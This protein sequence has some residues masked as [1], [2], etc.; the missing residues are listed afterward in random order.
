MT[1]DDYFYFAHDRL[2]GV[3]WMTDHPEYDPISTAHIVELIHL[4]SRF[5]A[6]IRE[7]NK[8]VP[9]WA[10]WNPDPDYKYINF[11][12]TSYRQ[13][14]NL[15]ENSEQDD[16]SYSDVRK[17]QEVLNW[18]GIYDNTHLP[19]CFR[20][21]SELVNWIQDFTEPKP[22][23]ITFGSSRISCG[24]MAMMHPDVEELKSLQE[25]AEHEILLHRSK[26]Q[27]ILLEEPL[28]QIQMYPPLNDLIFEA[29]SEAGTRADFNDFLDEFD[30]EMSDT[31]LGRY[32]S[33]GRAS[34]KQ[35][36][37]YYLE[38]LSITFTHQRPMNQDDV[39]SL[40]LIRDQHLMP[41]NRLELW[42]TL[43][44]P[45]DINLV[46]N[47]EFGL[48][49]RLG[50][51]QWRPLSRDYEVED[52]FDLAGVTIL[53]V[54]PERESEV[55]KKFDNG[56]LEG[57][58]LN[59][60]QLNRLVLEYRGY[61]NQESNTYSR[62]NP[63][64]RST[65]SFSSLNAI[66]TMVVR[67]MFFELSTSIKVLQTA[68][69]DLPYLIDE[70]LSTLDLFIKGKTNLKYG[71]LSRVLGDSFQQDEFG[72]DIGHEVAYIERQIQKQ[73][74]FEKLIDSRDIDYLPTSSMV[75]VVAYLPSP[76]MW[77]EF[78][79]RNYEKFAR[80]DGCWKKGMSQDSKYYKQL[81]LYEVREECVSDMIKTY[82]LIAQG[83]SWASFEQLAPM[84]CFYRMSKHR[85]G[86]IF[87]PK[88]W[89]Y[90]PFTRNQ[91]PPSIAA[92]FDYLYLSVMEFLESYSKKSTNED[93]DGT[94]LSYWL[95]MIY[96]DDVMEF[97][98]Q[99]S[100]LNKNLLGRF[101]ANAAQIL[102]DTKSMIS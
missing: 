3:V 7:G 48:F 89:D 49:T 18:E 87:N 67:D 12:S 23:I 59:D 77:L 74:K 82:D 102:Q 84:L 85:V 64:D 96:A 42:V 53:Q 75:L 56:E 37:A 11:S 6:F 62:L 32:L 20:D 13:V 1:D 68:H 81:S 73:K 41:K 27:D 19:E 26:S 9:L 92:V 63:N 15:F 22:E 2:V 88:D 43:G 97:M 31:T 57:L 58:H 33:G 61:I 79:S 38:L 8:W 72:A 100:T 71:E 69:F 60:P 65:L 99:D 36:N 25:S 24:D 76:S 95:S 46:S 28:Y 54:R 51:N 16:I 44:D 98:N 78:R 80:I 94:Q 17:Y 101:L 14:L 21:I 5:G 29:Y 30:E 86:E 90:E 4:T 45:I 93:E 83:D 52:V 40:K 55:I 34:I 66:A 39:D 47:T 10:G 50:K 91:M 70:K 35:L